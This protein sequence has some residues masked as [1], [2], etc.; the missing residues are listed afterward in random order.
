MTPL[1]SAIEWAAMKHC[2]TVYGNDGTWW[3][4]A[5]F[6]K[7]QHRAAVI[8]YVNAAAKPL[9]QGVLR[10]VYAVTDGDVS[11]PIEALERISEGYGV[12]LVDYE[13]VD[14]ACWMCERIECDGN[15]ADRAWDARS[16]K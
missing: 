16:G 7:F 5:P 6:E 9:I 14:G 1:E 4:L 11:V 10:E 3:T 2:A 15:C 13:H 8:D 12:T